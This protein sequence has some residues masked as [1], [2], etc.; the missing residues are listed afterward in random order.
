[1]I[2]IENADKT[3]KNKAVLI[4]INLDLEDGDYVLLKGHNGCGKTML[5]RLM[6]GLITPDN[7]KVSVDE[8]YGYGLIIENPAFLLGETAKYNLDYLASLNHKIDGD[9][10]DKYLK[11]FGLYDVR[12]KK[13]RTFSLGMKQRLALVQAVMENPDILLLDEPFNAID[14]GNVAAISGFLNE[15]HG[16]KKIIVIASHGESTSKCA[17]N[18]VV[19]MNA[20]RITSDVRIGKKE[21][22][23]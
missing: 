2:H 6:A 12:N 11:L 5:L 3:I 15:F 4:D 20:G 14:E 7:G 17:F 10:I 22:C 9:V 1:M 19:T 21:G 18:R 13:V 16:D 8:K 23:G